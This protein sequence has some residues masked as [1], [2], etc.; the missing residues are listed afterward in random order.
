MRNCDTCC[1][2]GYE[3]CCDVGYESDMCA[4]PYVYGTPKVFNYTGGFNSI[5]KVP[6]EDCFEINNFHIVRVIYHNPATIVFWS[7]GTK[8]V[9]KCTEHDVYSKEI[10]VALCVAKKM[11][12]ATKLR[13]VMHTWS[14]D[15]V[16]SY[17]E[18]GSS[19]VLTNDVRKYEKRKRKAEEV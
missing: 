11:C 8:T 2:V 14:S 17:N 13:E 7:D 9:C 12:G 19:V 10:G 6:G 1:G 18:D 15:A 16:C 3:T 4:V 5:R